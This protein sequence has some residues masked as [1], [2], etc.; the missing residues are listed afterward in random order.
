MQRYY[1]EFHGPEPVDEIGTEVSA[2]NPDDAIPAAREQIRQ[3]ILRGQCQS[4]GDISLYE[5][6]TR[7]KCDIVRPND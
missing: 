4:L 5:F 1:V 3:E 2:L 7:W 6:A